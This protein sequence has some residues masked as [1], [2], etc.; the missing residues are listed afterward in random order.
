M[1][2]TVKLNQKIAESGLKKNY[3]ADQ[4]GISRYAFY[5]KLNG[6]SDFTTTEVRS[7]CNVLGIKKLSEKEAIFFAD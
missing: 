3:I 5:M 4:L 2:N 1:P 7:L 6:E